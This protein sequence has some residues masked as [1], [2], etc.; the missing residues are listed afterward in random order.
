MSNEG[1]FKWICRD[2]RTYTKRNGRWVNKPLPKC[3]HCGKQMENM[4]TCF[5]VPKKKDIKSWATCVPR[6]Y[7]G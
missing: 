4:G 3:Q 2:C 6:G 1:F 7:K 5:E